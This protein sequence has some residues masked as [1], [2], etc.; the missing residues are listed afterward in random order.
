[1]LSDPDNPVEVRLFCVEIVKAFFILYNEEDQQESRKADGQRSSL[2]YMA[3][4][5][6]V[7]T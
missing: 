5:L 7:H 3:R 6:M 4:R 1:M 2:A